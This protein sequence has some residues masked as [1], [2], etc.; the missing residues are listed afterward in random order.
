MRVER[1]A[2]QRRAGTPELVL[3]CTAIAILYLTIFAIPP[4][5][6]RFV[7]D[8]GFSYGQAGFLMTAFTLAYAVGSIP[9][10]RLADR[11]GAGSVMAAGVILAGL[12]SMACSLTDAFAPLAALRIVIGIGN[13]LTWTAGAIYIT[14]A[15]GP[16]R[17]PGGI[18]LFVSS[19]SLGVAIAFLVTPVLD[20]SMHWS[21]ILLLYGV[22]AV[23]AGGLAMAAVR[24]LGGPGCERIASGKSASLTTLLRVPLL[25]MTCLALFLGMFVL[26]A[27]LTWIP[28]YMEDVGQFSTGQRSV[29]GL[30]LAFAAVPASVVAGSLTQRTGRPEMVAAAC[31]VPCLPLALLAATTGQSY[32][33]V[34]VIAIL[35]VFG[36]TAAVTPLFSLA[37]GS[38]PSSSAGS[39]IGLATTIGI[40]GTVLATWLGGVVVD[41]ASYSTAL[42]VFAVVAV[43]A[44]IVAAVFVRPLREG[45]ERVQ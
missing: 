41:V 18:G 32:V 40:S 10:G 25:R 30:L 31:L 23:V 33:L 15:V 37:G 44:I 19:L 39:A 20:G 13:A 4:L 22:I 35:A 29:G 9:A 24:R 26:Y 6:P 45:V 3:A 38:V 11:F 27:V 14:R 1:D 5:I 43:L 42:V 8:E 16:A 12:A 7:D 28:P 34:V 36:S 2:R 17:A 21:T